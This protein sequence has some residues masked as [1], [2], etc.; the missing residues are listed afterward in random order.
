M[1]IGS[2]WEHSVWKAAG[3]MEEWVGAGAGTGEVGECESFFVALDRCGIKSLKQTAPA[4][5]MHWE[6]K[7]G[8]A[9]G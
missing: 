2:R 3:G 7:C 6:V 8:E 5:G 9:V 4:K 1:R